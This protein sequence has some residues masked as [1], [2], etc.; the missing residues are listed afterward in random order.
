MPIN[1]RLH[2]HEAVRGVTNRSSYLAV[3]HQKVDEN[4]KVRALEAGDNHLTTVRLWFE[5]RLYAG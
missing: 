2:S 5:Q 1:E 4:G 3:Q